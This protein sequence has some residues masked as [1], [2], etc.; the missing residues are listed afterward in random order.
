MRSMVAY[1]KSNN[2]KIEELT[3]SETKRKCSLTRIK[4]HVVDGKRFCAWCITEELKDSRRKY[5]S[6]EC[7]INMT[8]WGYPQKEEGLGLLLIRQQYKCNLCQHDWAP[9]VQNIITDTRIPPVPRNYDFMNNY[10]WA[11]IKRLKNN[12]ESALAPEV[13]HIVP[14][15]KGGQSLGLENHQAICYTCHKAKSK[16]DNA[17]PRK[18][19]VDK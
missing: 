18:K 15:Y 1:K 5:C 9:A 13:D 8:A 17:G 16:I 12:C 19:K 6:E 3:K 4:V 10:N 7:S 2:P 14:V 11:L